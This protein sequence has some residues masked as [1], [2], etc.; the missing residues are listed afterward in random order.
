MHTE[1]RMESHGRRGSLG[2]GVADVAGFCVACLF[3]PSRGSH[4]GRCH[5]CRFSG[6][7]WESRRRCRCCRVLL[8]LTA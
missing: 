4:D 6:D 1:E 8:R 7:W 5:F 3:F 2:D